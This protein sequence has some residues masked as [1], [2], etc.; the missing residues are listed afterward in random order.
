M[1]PVFFTLAIK[2]PP[3]SADALY[4]AL[5]GVL[6]AQGSVSVVAKDPGSGEVTMT[7]IAS[8]APSTQP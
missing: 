5:V 3:M 4:A 2:N 1:T 8:P 7:F 6:A